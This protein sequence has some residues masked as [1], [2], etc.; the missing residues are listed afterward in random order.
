MNALIF[1]IKNNPL[2]AIVLI[3]DAFLAIWL[4]INRKGFE[5]DPYEE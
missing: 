3:L 1:L 4:F 5:I 2:V